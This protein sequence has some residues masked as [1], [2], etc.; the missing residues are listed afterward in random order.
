LIGDVLAEIETHCPNCKKVFNFL[1]DDVPVV[2]S[3]LSGSDIVHLKC[4]HCSIRY[5]ID[6]GDADID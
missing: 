6:M 2:D 1:T 3:S 5:T 4:P